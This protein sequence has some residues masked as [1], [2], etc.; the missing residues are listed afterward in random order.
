M[1]LV[2]I[3]KDN[4]D[5]LE[6]PLTFILYKLFK[7]GVYPKILEFA[8]VSPIHKK[9]DTLT[10]SKYCPISLSLFSNIFEKALYHKIY[11]FLCKHKLINTNQTGFCSNHSTEPGL[12]SFIE[13][14]KKS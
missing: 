8:Q 4:I 1:N 14:I 9:E 2:T 3:P 5:I 12:I 13:T 10:V 6:R 7:V 11:S